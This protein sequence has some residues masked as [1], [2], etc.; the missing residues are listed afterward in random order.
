[1]ATTTQETQETQPN[2][3]RSTSRRWVAVGLVVLIATVIGYLALG[4]PGMAGMDGGGSGATGMSN[5]DM[6]VS[7][8]EFAQRKS[9]ADAFVVNVHVP[10]EGS[11]AGTDVAIPYDRVALDDRLPDDRSTPILLYC[12][13]GRMSAEAAG[14]LMKA[15]YRN[16]VYLD[17][18]MNAWQAAGRPLA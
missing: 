14:A 7:V 11:I 2:G 12:K 8:D 3:P 1:M 9:K 13:T 5:G 18:G 15:G 6:A 4:M 10:D 16:V 17:G